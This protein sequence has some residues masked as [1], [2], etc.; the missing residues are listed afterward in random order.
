MYEREAIVKVL[1]K[2]HEDDKMNDLRNIGVK[3]FYENLI[4]TLTKEDL[5]GN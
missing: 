2:V 1:I 3:S 5:I 4:D